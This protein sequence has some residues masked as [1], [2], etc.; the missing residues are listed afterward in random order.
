MNTIIIDV[1]QVV[2]WAFIV[3]LAIGLGF[4]L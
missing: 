2:F 4:V 3:I 1:D